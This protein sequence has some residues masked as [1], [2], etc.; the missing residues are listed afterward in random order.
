MNVYGDENVNPLESLINPKNLEI[1]LNEGEVSRIFMKE[2]TIAI[3][4]EIKAREQIIKEVLEL[5]PIIGVEILL[6]YKTDIDFTDEKKGKLV[7]LYN[8]LQSISTM[9]GIEYYS[10]SRKRMRIFYHDAYVINSPDEKKKIDDPF[11]G[12]NVDNNSDSIP[13][14]SELF[15]YLKDSSFGNYVCH[16]KYSYDGEAFV[17]EMQNL[18][19]IWYTIIPLIKPYKLKSYIIIIPLTREILFYGFS[20][21]RTIDLFGMA[22]G[23]KES[24]YYRI[25][26]LYDWFRTQYK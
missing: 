24:L 2:Q 22:E 26:A 20:C 15:A 4:P 8:V 6:L 11:V 13:E 10:Y 18:T 7:F 1:L 12:N 21:L 23:R 19:Q 5:D 14:K 17:M 3:I 16:I 9:K 25:K